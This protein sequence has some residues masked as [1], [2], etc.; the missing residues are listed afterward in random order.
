MLQVIGIVI[1]SFF[2]SISQPLTHYNGWNSLSAASSH[3]SC[4]KGKVCHC[5]MEKTQV[6]GSSKSSQ[7][8]ALCCG[9][10]K[11]FP[12]PQSTPIL[13][14]SSQIG[15]ELLKNL[16]V[17]NEAVTLLE[18]RKSRILSP[19]IT[20]SPHINSIQSFPLRV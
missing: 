8:A 19:M 18:L 15:N 14:A 20:I 16:S 3:C 11:H 2:L 4:C 10:T 6:P 9:K 13:S 12:E 7:R 5:G 17:V 1:S